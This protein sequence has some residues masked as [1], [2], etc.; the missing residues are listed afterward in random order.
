[1]HVFAQKLEPIIRKFT[2]TDTSAK[3]NVVYDS[4][5]HQRWSN[6]AEKS[7]NLQIQ[8]QEHFHSRARNYPAQYFNKQNSTI[9]ETTYGEKGNK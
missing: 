9:N 4:F 7:D 6:F 3:E 5:S 8:L 1:M 2:T